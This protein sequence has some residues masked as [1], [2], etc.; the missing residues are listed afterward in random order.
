MSSLNG[1][2]E[3]LNETE[4]PGACLTRGEW[5]MEVYRYSCAYGY[6]SGARVLEVGGWRRSGPGVARPLRIV[7]LRRRLR[8]PAVRGRGSVPFLLGIAQLWRCTP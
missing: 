4:L 7:S 3:F 2:Y 6:V 8:R 5:D 1:K